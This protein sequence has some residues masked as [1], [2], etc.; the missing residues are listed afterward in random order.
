MAMHMSANIFLNTTTRFV[1]GLAQLSKADSP[2]AKSII[3]K[4]PSPPKPTNDR[5]IGNAKS[6]ALTPKKAATPA[7]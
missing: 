4:K 7:K 5:S 6:N 3:D 2:T 1:K